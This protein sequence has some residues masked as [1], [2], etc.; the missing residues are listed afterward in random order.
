MPEVSAQSYDRRHL[1]LSD[2]EFSLGALQRSLKSGAQSS[3]E[4]SLHLMDLSSLL[5]AFGLRVPAQM[6][7][8]LAQD[9]SE[10]PLTASA[11]AEALLPLLKSLLKALQSDQAD[12]LEAES[13]ALLDFMA[14]SSLPSAESIAP[15][16]AVPLSTDQK[17]TE[18]VRAPIDHGERWTEPAPY[19]SAGLNAAPYSIEKSTS[20]QPPTAEVPYQPSWKQLRTQVLQ[21]VQDASIPMH[22]DGQSGDISRSFALKLMAVQDALVRVGQLPV[23]SVLGGVDSAD[24]I[25]LDPSVIELLEHL[26]VFSQRASRIAMQMRNLTVFVHW[27]G[28]TLSQAEIEHIG[29]KVSDA[30]GRVEFLD[31]G[32]QLVLPVSTQRMRMVSYLQGGVWHAIS[33]AQFL[34]WD[35]H[36]SSCRLKLRCGVREQS[37]DVQE[38]GIV[39]NMNIYP[40]PDL[41]PAP[42]SLVGLALDGS[43]RVHQVHRYR[44]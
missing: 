29:Q 17:P 25:W 42:A 5:A 18:S 41:V 37:L 27:A 7:K 14:A 10:D 38:A 30:D 40:W 26:Q 20:T 15:V 22:P 43:G 33:Q 24:E 19:F 35:R 8:D 28:A 23:R 9:L 32:V 36:A 16:P 11:R 2:G 12:L 21:I 3:G 6:L 39:S 34:G 44:A 13:Q 4:A 31:S 1:L